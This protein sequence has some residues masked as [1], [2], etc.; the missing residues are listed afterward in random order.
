MTVSS[1][2]KFMIGTAQW[3]SAYGTYNKS[4]QCNIDEIRKIMCFMRN[5]QITDIDT[6]MLY[7]NAHSTIRNLSCENM[8]IFTKIK[9]DDYFI[10]NA[11]QT[12]FLAY[13]LKIDNAYGLSIHNADIIDDGNFDLAIDYLHLIKQQYKLK[14]LGI[15]IYEVEQLVKLYQVWTPDIIQIPLNFFNN[16]FLTS[17]ALEFIHK[18]GTKIHVRS[19]F[20]QGLLLQ[21]LDDA[22]IFNQTHKNIFTAYSN[23]CKATGLTQLEAC[24]S[25]MKS[26]PLVDKFVLG[27]DSS[28]QLINVADIYNR[29]KPLEE[30]PTFDA[31]IELYD[32]RYWELTK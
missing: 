29:V 24:L 15:S 21:D 27:F 9:I 26:L 8:K 19:L 31:P 14:K 25:L 1:F 17:G 7:G 6:S 32:P 13:S 28:E 3:G 10:D 20:C 18:Q 4:G 23:W 2:E 30:I 22:L 5:N 11:S 16:S 12:N